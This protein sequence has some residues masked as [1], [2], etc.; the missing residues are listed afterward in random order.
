M[1]LQKPNIPNVGKYTYCASQPV[2]WNKR[3]IIGSFV[4]IGSGVRLGNGN[5]PL[6]FLSTSPYL[7]L[8]RLKFKSEN[9][10]PRT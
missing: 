9:P 8:D 10:P 6:N 3:T 1:V 4:S 5:H 2:I 7:Y